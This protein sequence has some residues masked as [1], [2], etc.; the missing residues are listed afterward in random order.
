MLATINTTLISILATI[1]TLGILILIHELGHFLAARSVGIRVERFSIGFP[2]RFLS[3]RNKVDGLWVTIHIPWFLQKLFNAALVEY[4]F[5]RKNPKA[6]D[7]EYN[8]SWTPLGGYV[9]MAGTI[10]ESLDTTIK[11]KPWEFTSKKRWQQLFVISAGVI[12]NTILAWFLFSTIFLSN[13]VPEMTNSAVVGS[14][15]GSQA[16]P[17]YPAEQAGIQPG[18]RIVSVNNQ[19][20][21]SWDD[22]IDVIHGLPGKTVDI[23]WERGSVLQSATLTT[24]SET[25]PTENGV[26]TYG[27]IGI[28]PET[29]QREVGFFEA[30]KLG[31][32]NT[33][34][35]GTLMVR[36]LGML[37]SG[38]A[39]MKELGGPVAI[40]K[41]AGD[42][43]KQGWLDVFYFMAILSVNLAFINILPIPGLD[44]GQ[45]IIIAIEG[46][47]RRPLPIKAKVVIQQVGMVL[48]L[49]LIIYVTIQDI[50]KL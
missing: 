47:I 32:Q 45:F 39:S 50:A 48:L 3:F 42:M 8:V 35:F 27:M 12:M 20:I 36:S 7:T 18:D 28:G 10:D 26:E 16:R 33:Y 41:M 23:T 9:K 5:R 11:G 2:P 31:A 14:L 37:I 19:Q 17:V 43:A 6:G 4:R 49:G 44:G 1:F 13:G 29:I 15:S 25:V 46:L 21:N 40:A 30:A 24:V 22:L 38:D 34:S